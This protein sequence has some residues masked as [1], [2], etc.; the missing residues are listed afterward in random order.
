MFYFEMAALDLAD[1]FCG[2]V[3]TGVLAWA[4]FQFTEKNDK[5]PNWFSGIPCKNFASAQTF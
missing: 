4:Y 3:Y 2:S 1:V 5:L